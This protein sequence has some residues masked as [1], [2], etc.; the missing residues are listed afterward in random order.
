MRMKII[1][2]LTFKMSWTLSPEKKKYEYA[3]IV[4]G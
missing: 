1:L 3:Y 2:F 4:W